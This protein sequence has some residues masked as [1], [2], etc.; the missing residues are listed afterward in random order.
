M[1][2]KERFLKSDFHRVFNFSSEIHKGRTLTFLNT[3]IANIA[4]AVVTGALYT[5]FLAENGIDI[6]RVGIISFIPYIS[7]LI[8]I[9]SPTILS[10][11][12]K[13]QKLLL[14]NDYIYYGT[15]VFGTTIMPLFVED[16][17]A[18]TVWFAVLILIGNLSNALVGSGYT[19]WLIKF[20][21]KD[22]DLNVYVSWSNAVNLVGS[23]I[24]GILASIA[25]TYIAASGNRFM[26]LFW[27][28]I[29]ACMA[30]IAGS[31][32]IYL[33]P[34]ETPAPPEPVR[35][36]P[37]HVLTEPVKHRPF[38]LTVLLA[39]LWGFAV[40]MNTSTY[41][42]YLL[43]TVKVPIACMYISAVSAMAGSLFLSGIFRRFVD[44]T[45]PFKAVSIFTMMFAVLEVMYIFIAPGRL[46]LYIVLSAI[47]GIVS[48]GFSMGYNGIFYLN[49]P[50]KA[51][52]D[53]YSTLWNLAGGLAA[54]VGAAS[55]T[56]LLAIFEKQGMHNVFG[57]Q[58]YGSQLLTAVRSL[59]LCAAGLFAAV[60]TPKLA[61]RSE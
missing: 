54:F 50:E 25:A 9:F 14:L 22:K 23:N 16:P 29:V 40:N 44:R 36:L 32:M 3:G 4:N 7:W 51:N 12:R 56:W 55:G 19:S 38:M 13:R 5:A 39:V 20:V 53:L 60:I 30:L 58:M 24:T 31:M 18:K 49:I 42:Y 6:V 15:I 45:S 48:V 43:E 21:P 2:L 37:R 28:R 47:D 34:K 57:M 33:I 8:S 61:K 59:F 26:F 41:S 46:M 35:I 27:L 52:R 17:G 1:S 10:K 11:F